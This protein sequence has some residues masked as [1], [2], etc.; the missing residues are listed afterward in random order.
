MFSKALLG[1]RDVFICDYHFDLSPCTEPFVIQTKE[2][3]LQIL[4]CATS[5]LSWVNTV[6]STPFKALCH[7]GGHM[8]PIESS[9]LPSGHI[10]VSLWFKPETNEGLSLFLICSFSKSSTLKWFPSTRIS[11]FFSS[12]PSR[13]QT[14]KKKWCIEGYF[15]TSLWLMDPESM[16]CVALQ[17]WQWEEACLLY[18]VGL[19]LHIYSYLLKTNLYLNQAWISQAT[20]H[21]HLSV[22]LNLTSYNHPKVWQ[23]W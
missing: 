2:G 8:F 10:S 18:R 19:G 22:H 16:T 3:T 9:L 15:Y 1:R 21:N 11:V 5:H 20:S 6:G 13:Y 7:S 12:P 4:W 14:S 23:I 17:D